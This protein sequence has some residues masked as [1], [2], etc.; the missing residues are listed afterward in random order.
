MIGSP[1]VCG[2]P[3]VLNASLLNAPPEVDVNDVARFVKEQYGIVGQVRPLSGERDRTFHISG[4]ESGD[5]VFKVAHPDEDPETTDL[6]IEV[7]LFLA[8]TAR[9][10][11]TQRVIASL[12]GRYETRF[13]L[14]DGGSSSARLLSFIPGE[15]LRFSRPSSRQRRNV[16]RLCAEL[17]LAL[18]GFNHPATRQKLAW[19]IAQAGQLRSLIPVISKDPGRR[20]LLSRCLDNFD[21]R[22]AP[23]LP[24]F[25]S[26]PVHND[27]NRNNIIVSGNDHDEI[28]AII[29]FGDMVHTALANDV[30]IG[31]ANQLAEAGP[32]FDRSFEFIAGYC[33]VTPLTDE[34]VVLMHDLISVR[35]AASILITEWR[36]AQFPERRDH[37]TRNTPANWIRLGQLSTIPRER[38]A[39]ALRRVCNHDG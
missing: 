12:D 11:P 13:S 2:L 38:T 25:R 15:L 8:S 16:G 7:L 5:Y 28:A 32:L 26:Q 1:A 21:E 37:I 31:A 22:V 33:D 4:E 30:A 10:L 14:R 20:N 9:H 39:A 34:E 3:S 27:F 29:D 23:A 19:D 36:A 18:R 35:V 6:Q 17:G 24:S